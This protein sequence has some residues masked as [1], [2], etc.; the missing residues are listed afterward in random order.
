MHIRVKIIAFCFIILSSL[1][2]MTSALADTTTFTTEQKLQMALAWSKAGRNINDAGAAVNAWAALGGSYD[3]FL[4]TVE[5]APPNWNPGKSYT[6]MG[7]LANGYELYTDVER[8]QMGGAWYPRDMNNYAAAINAWA[9]LGGTAEDFIQK[10]KSMGPDWNPAQD[11]TNMETAWI[12]SGHNLEDFFITYQAAARLGMSPNDIIAAIKND[13][14]WDPGTEERQRLAEE[15]RQRQLDE[16]QRLAEENAK[17]LQ[18]YNDFRDELQKYQDLWNEVNDKIN[19]QQDIDWNDIAQRLGIEPSTPDDIYKRL[20][21]LNYYHG[22]WETF[23]QTRTASG[24]SPEDFMRWILGQTTDA[25]GKTCLDPAYNNCYSQ[26]R[27]KL[28]EILNQ[29]GVKPPIG[30]ADQQNPRDSD[31]FDISFL[32]EKFHAQLPA[33]INF[34]YALS[35]TIGIVLVIMALFKLKEY[36][37][38]SSSMY[39]ES[40]LITRSLAY[41]I[42]G[43]MLI[44]LP[45]ALDVGTTTF[46]ADNGDNSLF[47]YAAIKNK[48]YGY[49]ELISPV[50]DIV[51]IVGLLAFI[52][53]WVMLSKMGNQQHK[54]VMFKGITHLIG[55]ILAVNII[56]VYTIFARVLGR[57]FS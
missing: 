24:Q 49:E 22:V 13:P 15:E 8:L 34:L 45:S 3:D 51:K 54:G 19:N 16:Q 20:G 36:S 40:G 14:N 41:F 48:G 23:D 50:I 21:E 46:L 27:T 35:Y 32:I 31:F 47:S 33:F 6:E 30:R 28:D 9:T 38:T 11:L 26:T 42:A 5:T 57:L 2:V 53:G 25:N 17:L 7:N 4:K 12:L 29:P 44:Y 10:A 18:Q 43:A 55:G 1:S 37:L 39:G 52:R 56:G